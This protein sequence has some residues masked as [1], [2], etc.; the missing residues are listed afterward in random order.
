VCQI[1]LVDEPPIILALVSAVLADNSAKM[2]L[3]TVAPRLDIGVP[4]EL[5]AEMPYIDGALG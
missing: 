1:P 3:L 5:D 4:G 2:R